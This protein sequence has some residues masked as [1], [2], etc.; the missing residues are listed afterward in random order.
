MAQYFFESSDRY[1]VH[2]RRLEGFTGDGRVRRGHASFL[3]I[4]FFDL[5]FYLL[6]A[7][8][9]MYVSVCVYVEVACGGGICDSMGG[10]MMI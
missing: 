7:L 10:D 2:K 1:R 9:C 6:Y 4:L 5:M 8:C 3:F